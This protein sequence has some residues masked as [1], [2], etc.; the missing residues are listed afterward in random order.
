[1]RPQTRQSQNELSNQAL[2]HLKLNLLQWH[3][4]P[5]PSG[6]FRMK[7]NTNDDKHLHE[8]WLILPSFSVSL[9]RKAEEPECLNPQSVTASSSPTAS[10]PADSETTSS[11]CSLATEEPSSNTAADLVRWAFIWR[12]AA[13]LPGGPCWFLILFPIRGHESSATQ[14]S[15]KGWPRTRRQHRRPPPPPLP[16]RPFNPFKSSR[17]TRSRSSGQTPSVKRTNRR[18]PETAV[19]SVSRCSPPGEPTPRQ[20]TEARGWRSRSSRDASTPPSRGP[21]AVA[22]NRT[23][24]P[25]LQNDPAT[26]EGVRKRTSS[27]LKLGCVYDL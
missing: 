6:R 2:W 19:P 23:F 25:P 27:V 20:N 17:S 10:S 13:F 8:D 26:K 15:A 16:P 1:M 4:H 5:Q 24:P 22:K 3:H 9:P 11:T 18:R 7:S 14:R 21:G 12:C